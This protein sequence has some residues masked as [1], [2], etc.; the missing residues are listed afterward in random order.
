MTS[1]NKSKSKEKALTKSRKGDQNQPIPQ[2]AAQTP[3]DIV[4]LEDAIQL[5]KTS[6]TTLYRWI[7]EGKI[8]AMKAGRQWR[9]RRED[10]DWFLMGEQ[11]RTALPVSPAPLIELLERELRAVGDEPGILSEMGAAGPIERVAELILR[12]GFKRNSSDIHIA[13]NRADE[14]T[15]A[16]LRLRIDGVLHVIATFDMRLLPHLI[17]RLKA[18][19]GCDVTDT[20]R[21][22]FG[23][24]MTSFPGVESVDIRI[25]FVPLGLGPSVT[26][27][28]LSPRA[29]GFNQINFSPTDLERI[30]QAIRRPHGMVVFTGPTG[31]GKSTSMYAAL[32]A[33]ATSE[34]KVMSIEDPIEQIRPWVSQIEVRADE[35]LTFPSALRSIMRSD[36]DIVMCGEIRE[37][38][39][40]QILIQLALTGHLVFSTLHTNDAPSTLTRLMDIGAE[41]FLLADTLQLIVSQRLIRNVC[42]HCAR[43]YT[44]TLEELRWMRRVL[45]EANLDEEQFP[46]DYKEA[47]GC[48]K[49]G[50]T[51]YRGRCV[52]AETLTMTPELA[53]ALRNRAPNSEFRRLAIAGG[54]TP[55]A[56]DAVR[57]ASIGETSVAE[58]HRVTYNLP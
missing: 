3:G 24:I 53:A 9:F 36:P 13:P 39:T 2:Q 48:E 18:I 41:P 4:E 28:I 32:S 27:R 49:C 52:V 50:N 22:Q 35:G 7:R 23:R 42:V 12:L 51:G 46:K 30:N 45:V 40:L 34:N 1:K 58:A 15:E 47:V 29:V 54:M 33:I 8:K 16:V 20:A 14:V 26:M 5:L 31:S 44:P 25:A 19:S 21:P 6:R 55:M 56:A 17:D 38:E 37:L 10:L 43:P 11:P 57:R